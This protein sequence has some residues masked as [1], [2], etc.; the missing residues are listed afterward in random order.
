MPVEVVGEYHSRRCN[1]IFWVVYKLEREFGALMGAPS[2]IRD[3]DITARSPSELDD[4]FD[5]QNM[6]LHVRLSRLVSRILNG[7]QSAILTDSIAGTNYYQLFT[8]LE[9]DLIAR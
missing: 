2:S 1:L 6:S 5:A 7:T 8:E 3:E 9:G 4:C